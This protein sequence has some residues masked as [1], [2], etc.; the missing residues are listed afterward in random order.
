MWQDLYDDLKDQGFMVI[1]V[2]LDADPEAA[3]PWVEKAAPAYPVPIDTSHHLATLYNLVN[4]PQAVWIDE[5][6]RIVRPPETAGAY[7]AFRA[8]DRTSRTMPEDEA[9]KA[10]AA[11]N[12]YLAAIRDW[13][14]KGEN[15]EFVMDA[16]TARR[17]LARPTGDSAEAHALFRLALHLKAEG[18]A[19]EAAK[20][21][22]AATELNP[23]SWA[24]WRELSE[25]TEMGLASSPEFW[26][27]VD[28]LGDKRYYP[29]PPIE[30]MP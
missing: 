23:D 29:P 7:E 30:G 28:A 11:R 16:N 5:T 24:M 1:A 22:K 12:R 21:G 15:S 26:A 10:K 17:H 4:V 2:A 3:R 20:H 18:R 25:K 19:E 6:G 14:E 27:R 13:V 9:A 8:M